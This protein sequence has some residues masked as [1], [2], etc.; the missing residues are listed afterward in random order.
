MKLNQ[1]GT[2]GSNLEDQVGSAD[3]ALEE[4]QALSLKWWDD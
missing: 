1:R 3:Q 4:I 2:E